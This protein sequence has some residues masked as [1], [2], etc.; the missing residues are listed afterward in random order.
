MRCSVT[1]LDE[2][3]GYEHT[4]TII[5]AE[6]KEADF[7]T[8]LTTNLARLLAPVGFWTRLRR[9]FSPVDLTPSIKAVVADT[10]QVLKNKSQ[11]AHLEEIPYARKQILRRTRTRS[12]EENE[13][14]IR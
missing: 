13:G 11:I 5:L 9:A 1:L 6:W 3:A 12:D 8:T 4:S 7:T 2:K 14:T 10:L